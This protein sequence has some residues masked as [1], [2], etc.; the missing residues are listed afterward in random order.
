MAVV[1]DLQRRH[2]L[3]KKR[4]DGIRAYIG[5]IS[6]TK[7]RRLHYTDTNRNVIEHIK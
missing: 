3:Y 2:P 6:S 4:R 5:A 7:R 1:S